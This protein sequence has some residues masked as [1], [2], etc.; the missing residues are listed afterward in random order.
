MNFISVYLIFISNGEPIR[1]YWCIPTPKYS[2]PTDSNRDYLLAMYPCQY[3]MEHVGNT[4]LAF[5][6]EYV[7]FY[8]LVGRCS[9]FQIDCFRI[10]EQQAVPPWWWWRVSFSNRTRSVT[11]SEHATNHTI[12]FLHTFLSI[13]FPA[14]RFTSSLWTV[15]IRSFSLL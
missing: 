11:A 14:L 2:N 1:P 7:L 3:M 10:V 9:Y 13:F 12:T 4:T 6:G 8:C 15:Y 5:L